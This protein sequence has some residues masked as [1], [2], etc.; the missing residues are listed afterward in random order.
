MEMT[1]QMLRNPDFDGY[2]EG[3]AQALVMKKRQKS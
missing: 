1:W 2:E 3:V